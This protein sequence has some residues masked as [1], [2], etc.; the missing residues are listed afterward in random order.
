MK[1]DDDML[2]QK[3][4]SNTKILKS[5]KI[6]YRT[7]ATISHSRLVAAPLCFQAKNHFLCAFCVII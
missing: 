1:K 2:V 5:S 4:I 7:R 3:L 6:N